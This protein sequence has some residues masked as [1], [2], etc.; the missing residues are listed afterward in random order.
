[1][2]RASQTIARR[3]VLPPSFS[4]KNFL[5]LLRNLSSTLPSTFPSM[6]PPLAAVKTAEAKV[7]AA[8]AAKAVVV[9]M[10]A[11]TAVKTAAGLVRMASGAATA[12]AAAGRLSL[13]WWLRRLRRPERLGMVRSSLRGLRRRLELRRLGRLS[14]WWRL[15]WLRR[16]LR[17]LRRRLGRRL[18]WLRRLRR[19][20][21]RPGRTS[22]NG[23]TQSVSI[24]I[25]PPQ[26]VSVAVQFCA[27]QCVACVF[28]M[29]NHR[30]SACR[31]GGN[32]VP[33]VR[34]GQTP[35]P[36]GQ[37]A[38]GPAPRPAPEDSAPRTVDRAA[39]DHFAPARF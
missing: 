25:A 38:A 12:V 20:R 6:L 14:L 22:L 16:R 29:L 15:R 23:I 18:R 21:R 5:L 26:K 1:M 35:H 36:F 28:T 37:T 27:G 17:W 24:S 11:A 10:T 34:C 8:M 2:L 32:T 9:K 3:K 19:L 4:P 30:S 31:P 13:W 7:F 33:K 39:R